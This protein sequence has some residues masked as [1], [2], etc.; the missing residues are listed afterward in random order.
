MGKKILPFIIPVQSKFNIQQIDAV[1]NDV[2]VH[3]DRVR[4]NI[5][6]YNKLRKIDTDN[7]NWHLINVV[8]DFIGTLDK[9]ERGQLVTLFIKLKRECNSF[10]NVMDLCSKVFVMSTMIDKTFTRINILERA[11]DFA[12][13]HKLIQFVPLKKSGPRPK[14]TPMLTWEEDE[15]M[16]LAGIS[17]AYK[18]MFPVFGEIIHRVS[19]MSNNTNDGK[20]VYAASIMELHV[21]KLM[22]GT[23][24]KFNNYIKH[25]ISKSISKDNIVAMYGITLDTITKRRTATMLVKNLINFDLYNS[26]RKMITY[27]HTSASDSAKTNF[28]KKATTYYNDRIP[29]GDGEGDE[30]NKSLIDT[31]VSLYADRVDKRPLITNAVRI[32]VERYSKANNIREDV[33]QEARD[34]YCQ[35]V[36]SPTKINELIVSIFLNKEIGSAYSIRYLSYEWYIELIIVIQIYMARLGYPDLIPAMSIQSTDTPRGVEAVTNS[37]MIYRGQ[38]S[39]YSYLKAELVHIDKFVDV[40]KFFE[41]FADTI[42]ATE[43]KFNVPDAIKNLSEI[44]PPSDKGFWRYDKDILSQLFDFVYKLMMSSDRDFPNPISGGSS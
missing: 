31:S 19:S 30:T 32:M 21:A 25:A 4:F 34:F 16:N 39:A 27:L 38:G 20:E 2:N 28:N 8:N 17:I 43:H 5:V 11:V 1:I 29:F 7:N 9:D 15:Y 35:N 26:E 42:V 23:F 12:V 22:A 14:D 40:D 44:G 37:I 13:A 41:Q 6:T 18:M 24:D 33:I 36:P 3:Q 10:T